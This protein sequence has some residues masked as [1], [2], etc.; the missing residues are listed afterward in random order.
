MK[1]FVG[2]QKFKGKLYR[3]VLPNGSAK[4]ISVYLAM[5]KIFN[6]FEYG[7]F[8]EFTEVLKVPEF[9]ELNHIN[10]TDLYEE[11]MYT[12]EEMFSGRCWW[13]N[14]Y[15]N[16]CAIFEKQ[17]SEYGICYSFNSG[18]TKEGAVKM[19]R[20]LVF[21]VFYQDIIL[22]RQRTKVILGVL[23]LPEI[24]VPCGYRCQQL[25]E[26]KAH[27]NHRLMD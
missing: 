21:Q 11:V 25:L 14:K 27:F 16:C 1:Y 18:I 12:C 26:T 13:R 10:I 6:G 4:E 5:M 22:T 17:R 3:R 23:R 8:D 19:V 2:F 15:L 20:L 24:G 9:E 7:S